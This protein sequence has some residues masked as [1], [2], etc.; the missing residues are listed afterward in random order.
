[1]VPTKKN[2]IKEIH[3]DKDIYKERH[4]IENLFLKLK[5]YRCISTRYDKNAAAF[6][7]VI[8]L[9]SSVIWII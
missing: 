3:Y 1:V 6:L 4:V 2:R 8:Y 5:N 9:A 7:V